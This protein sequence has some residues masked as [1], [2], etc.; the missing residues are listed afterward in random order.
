MRQ[1]SKI[2]LLFTVVIFSVWGTLTVFSIRAF[3]C[4]HQARFNVDVLDRFIHLYYQQH[5]AYPVDLASLDPINVIS[6]GEGLALKS[7][8][9]RTGKWRGYAYQYQL[10]EKDK[11]VLSASPVGLFPSKVEFG[12][13][14]EGSIKM[15]SQSVDSNKDSYEEVKSW[16]TIPGFVDIVTR[17]RQMN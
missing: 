11:Y 9:L 6:Y 1:N 4:A 14:E 2:L 13:T 8:D 7:T 3:S 5:Q 15:N 10:I 17:E 16:P 12:I